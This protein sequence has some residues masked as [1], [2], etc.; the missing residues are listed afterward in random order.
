MLRFLKMAV[1]LLFVMLT[2]LKGVAA[3][4]IG[5]CGGNHSHSEP[6]EPKDSSADCMVCVE[7]CGNS[8]VLCHTSAEIS[9]LSHRNDGASNNTAVTAGDVLDRVFRPPLR[10]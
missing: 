7:H 4:T 6:A 9:L 1:V 3:L 10:L 2:P 5:F 8:T